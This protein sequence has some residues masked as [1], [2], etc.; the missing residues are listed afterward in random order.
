[1]ERAYDASQCLSSAVVEVRLLPSEALKTYL[2]AGRGVGLLRGSGGQDGGQQS[3]GQGCAC[4]A[5][6]RSG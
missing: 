1:M 2:S 3:Q 4:C 5:A 6:G